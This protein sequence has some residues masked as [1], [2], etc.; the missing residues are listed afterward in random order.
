MIRLLAKIPF[1]ER[2][3]FDY[4]FQKRYVDKESRAKLREWFQLPDG[5]K[6]YQFQKQEWLPVTRYEQMQIRLQEMES[7]IGREDLQNW[8]KLAKEA[9]NKSKLADVG[10]LI[11]A[12]EDR[13]NLLYDPVLMVRFISGI[14]IREDQIDTAHIWNEEIE[15]EKFNEIYTQVRAGG[16]ADFFQKLHLT[17]IVNFSDLS[18][19]GSEV[20]STEIMQNQVK[21]TAA[22]QRM[23]KTLVSKSK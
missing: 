13:V 5:T 7:R 21:Q 14:A 17:D 20:Y 9:V 16:L 2:Q 10:H 4:A 15:E 23:L 19:I 1:L 6:Y 22:F 11:G 18:I 3:I 12:L 8:L